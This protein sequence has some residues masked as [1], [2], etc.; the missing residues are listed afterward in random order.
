MIKREKNILLNLFSENLLDHKTEFK[1]FIE[2]VAYQMR[3]QS[4][5]MMILKKKCIR[6]LRTLDFAPRRRRARE[7]LDPL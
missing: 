5:I 7:I 3:L 2:K 6:T 1:T 4:L